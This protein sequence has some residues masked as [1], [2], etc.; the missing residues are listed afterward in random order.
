MKL[1]TFGKGL[2]MKLYTY[3][4]FGEGLMWVK[5]L[6]A[7]HR[8]NIEQELELKERDQAWW[9]MCRARIKKLQLRYT[10]KSELSFTLRRWNDSIVWKYEEEK[11]NSFIFKMFEILYMTLNYVLRNLQPENRSVL[12]KNELYRDIID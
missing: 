9:I 1:G 2:L 12:W 5:S 10:L 7:N 8:E 6:L 4:Q 11:K 3:H